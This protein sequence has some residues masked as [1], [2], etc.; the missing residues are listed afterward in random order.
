MMALERDSVIRVR[1]SARNWEREKSLETGFGQ[2]EKKY[3]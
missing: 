3:Q 2:G 1:E